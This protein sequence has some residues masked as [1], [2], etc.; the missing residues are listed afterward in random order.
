MEYNFGE[1][2]LDVEFDDDGAAVNKPLVVA[3]FHIDDED[4]ARH[5][6]IVDTRDMT[7]SK[8]PKPITSSS[9]LYATDIPFDIYSDI[10]SDYFHPAYMLSFSLTLLFLTFYLPFYL[11]YTSPLHLTFYQA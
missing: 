7:E 2:T 1:E 11:T 9:D 3:G 5:Q 4:D 10:L 6:L 8:L